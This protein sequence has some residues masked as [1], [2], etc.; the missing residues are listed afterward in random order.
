MELSIIDIRSFFEKKT[1][2]LLIRYQLCT[3]SISYVIERS[4][5]AAINF[6]NEYNFIYIIK[7]VLTKFNMKS[8]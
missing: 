5:T 6:N 2:L 7:E 8:M 4:F 3:Y 1:N